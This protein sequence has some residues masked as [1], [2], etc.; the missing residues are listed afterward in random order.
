MT[1]THKGMSFTQYVEHKG[2]YIVVTIVSDLDSEVVYQDEINSL[3]QVRHLK[4][5]IIVEIENYIKIFG[6][7]I[8]QIYEEV[9]EVMR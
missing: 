9:M 1:F 5:D 7:E 4:E 6:V 8:N 2:N 3:K